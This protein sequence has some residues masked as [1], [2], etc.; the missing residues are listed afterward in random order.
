MLVAKKFHIY[1]QLPHLA[2]KTNGPSNAVTLLTHIKNYGAGTA[3]LFQ[4]LV[5]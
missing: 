5:S 1:T 2:R 4:V 3:M